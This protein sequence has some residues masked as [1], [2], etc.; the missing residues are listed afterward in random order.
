MIELKNISKSF[1]RGKNELIAVNDVSLSI[2]PGQCIG[3]V[4]ESGCGKSTIAKLISGIIKPSKGNIE[5]LGV[6]INNCSKKETKEIRKN[7]QI[8]FQNPFDSFNPRMKIKDCIAE[9]IIY[10]DKLSKEEIENKVLKTMELVKLSKEHAEKYV[11]QISGGECQ[12]AAI[13]RAIISKPK[14][15]ICDEITSALDVSTQAQ[16]IN[17]LLELK[18][19]KLLSFL[20]IT[21]DLALLSSIC[22]DVAIMNEGRII[23]KGKT[24][25]VLE[26]PFHPYSKILR[27]CILEIGSD[28]IDLDVRY[29]KSGSGCKYIFICK[30]N[31]ELCKTSIP[32]LVVHGNRE[33]SCFKYNQ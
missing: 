15:L 29:N 12:R 14:L 17:L 24:R 5:F 31:L 23:E 8:V 10:Y 25:E 21:H 3:L 26:Y 33:I 20:F 7:I 32:D 9:G 6:D 13:A 16:I 11:S 30:S 2:N 28:S 4:G 22:D 27:T 19:Q 1:F 18:S